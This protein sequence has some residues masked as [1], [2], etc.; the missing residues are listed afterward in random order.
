L[1]PPE[2]PLKIPRCHCLPLACFIPWIFIQSNINGIQAE[3]QR[4]RKFKAF[5]SP[6]KGFLENL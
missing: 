4:T 3:G 1:N 6:L 2:S 5:E